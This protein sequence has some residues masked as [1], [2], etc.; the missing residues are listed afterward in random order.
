MKLRWGAPEK[1]AGFKWKGL[2]KGKAP[3]R[4]VG[5]QPPFQIR[6]K[7]RSSAE[8]LGRKVGILNLTDGSRSTEKCKDRWG[9][10]SL[11]GAGSP[12]CVMDGGEE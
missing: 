8:N 9:R 12:G 4:T 3:D 7:A 1:L 2:Q 11:K 10:R 6:P 5:S